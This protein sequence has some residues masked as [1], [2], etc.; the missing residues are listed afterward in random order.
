[1]E[2]ANSET[3]AKIRIPTELSGIGNTKTPVLICVEHDGKVTATDVEISSFDVWADECREGP[4]T[5]W[6]A[7]ICF[8]DQYANGDYAHRVMD[9]HLHSGRVTPSRSDDGG[10]GRFFFQPEKLEFLRSA[11]RDMLIECAEGMRRG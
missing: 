1:M 3:N 8:V 2:I 9:V 7:T 11:V 10:E 6:C 4:P 5:P